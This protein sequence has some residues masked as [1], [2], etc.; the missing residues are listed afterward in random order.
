MLQIALFL[1]T[2]PRN[3]RGSWDQRELKQQLGGLFMSH[4]PLEARIIALQK[5]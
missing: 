5:L 2:K 4:P 1:M 3:S